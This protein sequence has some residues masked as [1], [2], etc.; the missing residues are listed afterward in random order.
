M[1]RRKKYVMTH[2]M[3]YRK[4]WKGMIKLTMIMEKTQREFNTLVEVCDKA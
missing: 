1:M 4:K 3:E 2:T